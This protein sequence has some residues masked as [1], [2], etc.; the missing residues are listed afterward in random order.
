M[1]ISVASETVGSAAQTAAAMA[2]VQNVEILNAP[3]GGARLRVQP[4]DGAVLVAP[5]GDALKAANIDIQQ[6]Y[7]ERGA[8]DDVFREITTTSD[9]K[10]TA[11]A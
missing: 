9:T 2:G 5:L 3:D 11:H 4:M 7:V 6:I 8:L 1:V 10:E